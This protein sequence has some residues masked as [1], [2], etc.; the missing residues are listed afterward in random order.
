M[1]SFCPEVIPVQIPDL[2]EVEV[3]GPAPELAMPRMPDVSVEGPAPVLQMPELPQPTFAGGTEIDV[4]ELGLDALDSGAVDAARALR[5]L[6]LPN[7][8]EPR[9]FEW[10]DVG[11]PAWPK[12]DPPSVPDLRPAVGA[13]DDEFQAAARGAG[14][15]ADDLGSLSIGAPRI[16]VP[17]VD[18]RPVDD[19][20]SG[21]GAAIGRIPELGPELAQRPQ[22]RT[23]FGDQ[24]DFSS[25]N[26]AA[27]ETA[28][29]FEHMS[30][31]TVDALAVANRAIAGI[32]GESI[33]APAGAVD[34]A[35]QAGAAPA[36]DQALGASVGA[37]LGA[38]GEAAGGVV[39]PMSLAG[40]AASGMGAGL[41]VATEGLIAF[42]AALAA[43]AQAAA[44]Q[45][46]AEVA[47][48]IGSN[49][50]AGAGG[51]STTQFQAGGFGQAPAQ[52]PPPA[53]VQQQADFDLAIARGSGGIARG[54]RGEAQPGTVIHY[55]P[56]INVD[57]GR[58]NADAGMR[59]SMRQYER[60][61]GARA[62]RRV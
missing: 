52:R 14:T 53:Q 43:A 3:T 60:E 11:E 44:T 46:G 48:S 27:E 8:P 9:R 26:A 55:S 54:S 51:G 34:Q 23:S 56:T 1:N 18:L 5:G 20:V 7:V 2:P 10:P 17:S 39:V 58:G 29:K 25:V 13:L 61:F 45:A 49:I 47:G 15:F 24:L 31:E 22:G 57:G 40:E 16:D 28:R 6:E 62:R 38:A 33:G 37:S 42:V 41:G 36:V 32:A 30:K 35:L 4:P 59:F 19:A 50:A 12:I 21:V